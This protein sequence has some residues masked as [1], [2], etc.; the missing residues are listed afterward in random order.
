MSAV[1][2]RGAVNA[3]VLWMNSS[4]RY[5]VGFING[6]YRVVVQ[7]VKASIGRKCQI[8]SVENIDKRRQSKVYHHSRTGDR[9]DSRRPAFWD[10][11][12]GWIVVES[13][14]R[15]AACLSL[16]ADA[17]SSLL[18]G[19]VSSLLVESRCR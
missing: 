18:A 17:V 11:K 4:D 6:L 13:R 12:A 14:Y 2:G 7:N 3:N 1:A 10:K 9:T 15:R 8:G 5:D 19:A 16:L